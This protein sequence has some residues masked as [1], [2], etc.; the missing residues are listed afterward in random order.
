MS[1]R[2]KVFDWR[3]T[4]VV[5]PTAPDWVRD[6][7]HRRAMPWGDSDVAEILSSLRQANHVD[8]GFDA[9]GIHR[10]ASRRRESFMGVCH[11]AGLTK[12]LADALYESESDPLSSQPAWTCSWMHLRSPSKLAP[13]SPQRRYSPPSSG[14]STAQPRR[15]SWLAIA[16]DQT[17]ARSNRG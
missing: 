5:A 6:A 15:S 11:R 2:A 4:L 17:A 3:G 7:L 10:D 12:Q 8:N 13:R 16:P 1:F 14:Y 9:P